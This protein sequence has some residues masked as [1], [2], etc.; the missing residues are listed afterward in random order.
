MF[1]VLPCY[2]HLVILSVYTML[3]VA[4]QRYNSIYLGVAVSAIYISYVAWSVDGR[5]ASVAAL[6]AY[7]SYI[8]FI[9]LALAFF[10][11]AREYRFLRV[12]L[13]RFQLV[14]QNIALKVGV[15]LIFPHFHILTAIF[16]TKAVMKKEKDLLESILPGTMGRTL[17][18]EV[19]THLQD[20]DNFAR[21]GS[22]TR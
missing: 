16:L 7:A 3:P 2:D 10:I 5:E 6:I 8:L 19:K 4:Y 20:D 9:N 12:I 1:P 14:F 22:L 13:T 17:Q 15:L 21:S 11:C 18:E